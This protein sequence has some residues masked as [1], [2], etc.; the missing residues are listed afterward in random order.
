MAHQQH[1]RRTRLHRLLRQ[2]LASQ[3]EQKTAQPRDEWRCHHDQ[4]T[5]SNLQS[6]CAALPG[7]HHHRGDIGGCNAT[8]NAAPMRQHSGSGRHLCAMPQLAWTAKVHQDSI[9]RL[10]PL[11][12]SSLDLEL[13]RR[14]CR[15]G[16]LLLRE[17]G[18]PRQSQ[19]EAV[20]VTMHWK[21]SRSSLCHISVQSTELDHPE[22]TRCWEVALRL[23]RLLR[24]TDP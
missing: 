9:L 6:Q 17:A 19:S 14:Q 12:A 1:L 10:R 16:F 20:V 2:N 22:S 5:R 15:D 8:P 13:Q 4:P 7:T 11:I 24:P 23:R 21:D 3:Q 18:L